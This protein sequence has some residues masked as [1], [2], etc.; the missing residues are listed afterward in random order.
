MRL[1]TKISTIA[2]LFVA[3]SAT[4]ATAGLLD[5]LQACRVTS[6]L[7]GGYIFK[8]YGDLAREVA[9]KSKKCNSIAI[10]SGSSAYLMVSDIAKRNKKICIKPSA[11]LY[12]HL[13]IY[14]S[15]KLP[16]PPNN[17]MQIFFLS[18]VNA[19]IKNYFRLKGGYKK[20]GLDNYRNLTPIPATKTGIRLC[21]Y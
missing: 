17:F 18:K 13:A 11:V 14:D 12:M 4:N 5:Y 15:S 19:P 21:V 20:R 1:I 3:I 7:H 8:C 2:S 9:N 16:I 6:C 10:V